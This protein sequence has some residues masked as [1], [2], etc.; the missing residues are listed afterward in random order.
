MNRYV[1]VLVAVLGFA[2]VLSACGGGGSTI[3]VTI[4]DFAYSP[5]TFTVKAGEKVT[6]QATNKGA[7]EH[8]FAIMKLGT[9]VTPPFATPPCCAVPPPSAASR[10]TVS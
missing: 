4:T 8:E 3:K 2:L 7:V 5:N 9:S 10:P 6:L 1:K